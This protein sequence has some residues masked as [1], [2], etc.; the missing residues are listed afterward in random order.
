MRQ[1]TII[2]AV[3]A[4]VAISY[5]AA[6]RVAPQQVDDLEDT[7]RS[8]L[9][10]LLARFEGF[11][12]DPYQDQAGLWTIGFG[13]LIV[14]GDGFWHPDFNS[15]GARS[16]TVDD[17]RALKERDAQTAID[18]VARCVRVSLTDNQYNALVSLAYNIGAG[19]FCSSSVVSRLNAGDAIG[20]ANAFLLWNKITDP[21][22]GQLVVSAGLV[23]RRD[24]EREIFLA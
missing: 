4:L 19:A 9:G 15:G 23:R 7:V 6:R 24:Q 1:R 21:A 5:L 11:R 3:F 22:T 8:G 14:P 13:H 12:A 2:L 17:A 18:A 10:E 16:V 20:A